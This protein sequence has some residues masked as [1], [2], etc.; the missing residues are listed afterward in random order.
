MA[1]KLK[2]LDYEQL[3]RPRGRRLLDQE[4]IE[5]SFSPR[6]FPH[7]PA[8]PVPD[9]KPEAK[10]E[11]SAEKVLSPETSSRRV[12]DEIAPSAPLR[13][14]SLLRR[15][16]ALSFA[17]VFL[18]TL[19][20]YFRP[21]EL[22]PSLA[23]LSSSAF[24]IAI[25]TIAIFLPTQLGLEGNLTART[26]EVNLLLLLT[27]AALISIP[28]ALSPGTAWTSFTEYL[29]VVMI[30]VVMVN[31]VRTEKR[32]KALL[33]VALGASCLLSLAA[34]NDYRLGHLALQGTRISGT[35]GSEAA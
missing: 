27:L 25:L 28:F 16:H 17:G 34:L 10:E 14:S 32:L 21:Y 12:A 19:I 26:R 3:T 5:G 11:P 35:I 15:G 18:F 1:D 20:L 23:W 2:L 22:S 29:K 4:G 7:R 33:L 30:F 24:W 31:V 9:E 6:V 8:S 13:L